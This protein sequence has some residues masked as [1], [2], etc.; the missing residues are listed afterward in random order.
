MPSTGESMPA[1]EMIV[2]RYNE[3]I[4]WSLKYNCTVYNKGLDLLGTIK[5]DNVGREAHTYLRHVITNY[6]SLKDTLIFVQGNPFD[7]FSDGKSIDFDSLFYIDEKGYSDKVHDL[8]ND[9]W[10][11]KMSNKNDFTI[12]E[13]KGI[14][15]NPRGYKLKEWWEATTGEP[16]T[17][18]PSVFWGANFSVKKEF[19]MKRSLESYISIYQTLLHDRTPVEAHY[20]ERTWFNIFNLPMNR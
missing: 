2:A 5:I 6:H 11:E 12:S 16:Y 19:V 9:R 1:Y 20:C 18:S 10:G 14:I 7:H 17:R 15:S 13:W 4:S 8:S 3:D